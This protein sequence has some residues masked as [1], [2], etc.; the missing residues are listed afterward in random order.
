M[1]DRPSIIKL[2]AS[3]SAFLFTFAQITP[4]KT[5]YIFTCI[6]SGRNLGEKILFYPFYPGGCLASCLYQCLCHGCS[7]AGELQ[8]KRQ[9]CR[10][11]L[12][13][14]LVEYNS[15]LLKTLWLAGKAIPISYTV[16]KIV[17]GECCAALFVCLFVF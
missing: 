13:I 16:R 6:Q 3:D 7:S 12:L 17:A 10:V 15:F 9:G 11:Q 5:T 14:L 2:R 8:P 4:F 1:D